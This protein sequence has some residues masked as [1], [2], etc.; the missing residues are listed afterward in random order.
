MIK[1]AN[2]LG[3][4]RVVKMTST[5]LWR[6]MPNFIPVVTT[7]GYRRQTFKLVSP[8]SSIYLKRARISLPCAMS[9]SSAMRLCYLILQY[10][11]GNI[12]YSYIRIIADRGLEP[13]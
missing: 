2:H 5:D 1:M 11:M 7:K 8:G 12:W 3:S 13:S 6:C 9:A 10:G 4:N